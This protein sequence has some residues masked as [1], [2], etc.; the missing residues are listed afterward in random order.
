MEKNKRKIEYLTRQE[1]V[2]NNISFKLTTLQTDVCF[3][4]N[5][6]GNSKSDRIYYE[7]R[8]TP[9]LEKLHA[10]QTIFQATYIPSKR[11]DTHIVVL[12]NVSDKHCISYRDDLYYIEFNTH[13]VRLTNDGVCE[14]FICLQNV[15]IRGDV[16]V[17]IWEPLFNY[18]L[19]FFPQLF[20]DR[21][22]KLP[23]YPYNIDL[24]PVDLTR[25]PCMLPIPNKPFTE[26]SG[27]QV[28]KL[29]GYYA[30][31]TTTE[32]NWK[33]VAMRFGTVMEPVII[34]SY[35]LKHSDYKYKEPGWWPFQ[36]HVCDGTWTDGV[37]T[38]S[39]G[40]VFGL[41]CKASQNNCRFEG[42][43][44][45]QC[46]WSMAC[47]NTQW[48]DLVKYGEKNVRVDNVWT[49]V[50]ECRETRIMRNEKIEQEIVNLCFNAK[51]Y[52]NQEDFIRIINSEPYV[53][54]RNFLDTMANKANTENY[55]VIELDDAMINKMK[56]YKEQTIDIYV[57]SIHPII[58]R[59][60][61]RQ[62][63]IFALFQEEDKEQ[64]KKKVCQQIQD[65]SELI[66]NI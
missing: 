45:G 32:S 7:I 56:Q 36:N 27:S 63:N 57:P 14:M 23:F 1:C 8:F 31:T 52:K 62:A 51:K 19:G 49:K 65:Y 33:N 47:G 17:P 3:S 61:K 13:Q 26:I 38:D 6:I 24:G 20:P 11:T 60:E 25:I 15:Q 43:H 34:M 59:I 46:I 58:D 64:M 53:T 50:A 66:K 16:D 22:E 21:I 10:T 55:T 29:L 40:N 48:H 42:S 28:G 4:I 5:A 41:E 35:L 2:L 9:P 18:S 12:P 30:T 54:M 37:I 44:I 39:K